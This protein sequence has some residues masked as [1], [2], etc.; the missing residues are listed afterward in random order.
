MVSSKSYLLRYD[1]DGKNAIG[2]RLRNQNY[3]ACAGHDFG[4]GILSLFHQMRCRLLDVSCKHV[5]LEGGFQYRL[6]TRRHIMTVLNKAVA[7]CAVG[8]FAICGEGRA[9]GQFN[10]PVETGKLMS[11]SGISEPVTAMAASAQS[12]AS[13]AT[14]SGASQ[15]VYGGFQLTNSTTVYILVRGNSLKTLG[16]IPSPLDAP[17]VRV[18]NR[19]NR[20]LIN[21]NDTIPGSFGCSSSNAATDQPVIDYYRFTRGAPVDSRDFCLAAVFPAGVYTFDVTASVPGVTSGGTG[22]S[23]SPSSGEILFEVTLGP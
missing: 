14:V 17:W 9:S 3:A 18:Y 22:W 5:R 19:S 23:S 12:I 4:L 2:Y 15:K 8:M 10:V 11:A 13:R 21:T 20:D 6:P 7:A 1:L 16:I